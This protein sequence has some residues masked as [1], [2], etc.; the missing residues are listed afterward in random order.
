MLENSIKIKEEWQLYVDRLEQ[1]FAVNGIADEKKVPLML[2]VIGAETYRSLNDSVFS[3][4][5]KP[6][7]FK[8]LVECIEKHFFLQP[9]FWLKIPAKLV[10]L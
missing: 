5:P 4:K 3:A 8:E 6:K 7:T 10:L 1:F 9:R 2:N